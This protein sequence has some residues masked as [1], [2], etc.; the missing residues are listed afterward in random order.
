MISSSRGL[1]APLLLLASLLLAQCGDLEKSLN[2]E[3]DLYGAIALEKTQAS[4]TSA[5]TTTP[6]AV[7]GTT[8]TSGGTAGSSTA[9]AGSTAKVYFSPNHASTDVKKRCSSLAAADPTKPDRCDSASMA[10]TAARAQCT[11]PTC[12]V[13]FEFKGTTESLVCA[14]IAS[15]NADTSYFGAARNASAAAAEQDAL[16]ACELRLAPDRE[17]LWCKKEG[18]SFA[19][20]ASRVRLKRLSAGAVD[21]IPAEVKCMVAGSACLR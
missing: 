3:R 14:S 11:S 19:D 12:E 21:P 10:A 15:Y 9:G 8:G 17:S 5:G 4:T 1:V 16:Q 2:N 13:V 6:A 7:T 18:I 20:C